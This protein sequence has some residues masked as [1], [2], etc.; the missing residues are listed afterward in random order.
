MSET[1]IRVLVAL[2]AIVAVALLAWRGL[3]LYARR[4]LRRAMD[5]TPSFEVT[6]LESA[7]GVTR[8]RVRLGGT[9][10]PMRL[11]SLTAPEEAAR[12]VGLEPPSG[13]VEA[14]DGQGSELEWRPMEPVVVRPGEPLELEFGWEA[15]ADRVVRIFGHAEAG[16]GLGGVGTAFAVLAGPRP[17]L[18]VRA[19]N[20]RSAIFARARERGVVPRDLPE[21]KELEELE[22][23]LASD[24]DTG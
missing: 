18:E 24:D 5:H 11:E 22:A 20:L 7:G 10:E 2:A 16:M 4:F 15:A 12:S 23:R 3:R 21:W 17:A 13:F 9:E 6:V 14:G 19:S 1:L 8:V